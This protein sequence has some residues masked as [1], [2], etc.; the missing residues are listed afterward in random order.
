MATAVCGAAPDRREFEV[1][2]RQ[3]FEFAEKP[4]LARDGDRVTIRF[5]TRAF[6]DATVAIEKPRGRII[7]HLAC[8]VL[9][10]NAPE[11]FQKNSLEQTLVWDG[12]DDQ[13]KY[14]DEKD[15]V[16]VRVSLGLRARFERTLFWSPVKRWGRRNPLLA[17]APEGVYVF[18]PGGGVSTLQLFGHDGH[19]VRTVYPF[20]ADKV[21]TIEELKWY[22]FPQDGKRLPRK[23]GHRQCTLLSSGTHSKFYET[24]GGGLK[25]SMPDP[26]TGMAVHGKVIALAY[27]Y[28]NRF[29]T[30]GSS[31]GTSL[32]GARSG[33]R[34]VRGDRGWRG[35]GDEIDV[36]PA[37]LAFSPDA[38]WLYTAAYSWSEHYGT[39]GVH[40]GWLNGVGRVRFDGGGAVQPFAGNIEKESAGGTKP[41]EFRV[42]SGLACDGA[43]RVYVAD[44]L[45]DRVQVFSPAGKFL[46]QIDVPKPAEVA[47]DDKTGRIYVLSWLIAAKPVTFHRKRGLQEKWAVPPRLFVF[48]SFDDPKRVAAYDL[49]EGSGTPRHGFE[50][51]TW[52]DP[53]TVWMVAGRPARYRPWKRAGV[54]VI[55]LRDG[56]LQIT[57]DFG[58]AADRAIGRLEPPQYLRQRLY[59]NPTDDKVYLAEADAGVGKS[60]TDLLEIDPASGSIRRLS[61]PFDAED[62]AFDQQGRIYLRAL[63]DIARYDPKTWREIPFDYGEDRKGVGFAGS[64]GKRANVLSSLRIPCRRYNH[65]GGMMVNAR[66]DVVVG[67]HGGQETQRMR[68]AAKELFGD[69]GGYAFDLYP[70]RAT[71][72]LV[73]I[74]DR[75][76][77]AVHED[78]FPGIAF[79]HG[80]G[81][82]RDRSVYAMAMAHRVLG[83]KPYY[84]EATDTLVKV[85]PGRAKVYATHGKMVPVPL[86]K[87]LRPDRPHDIIG[88]GGARL[89]RAWV[90]RA[91]WFYGGVGYHGR[92]SKTDGFGCDCSNSRFDLD[93]FARSFAPEV[94]H[95]SVAVL[96]SAGNLILRVG[97]YGNVDD[98][99]PLVKAGGP[100]TPRSLGGDEVALF[101]APYVAIH[102]DRRLFIADPGN[103]RLLGVR[104]GY[105]ATET[106]A[107]R[108]V[109][110]RAVGRR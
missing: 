110:D 44:N 101:Y 98:G 69:K 65:H 81:I 104:L 67:I 70:G 88:R 60:T 59:A 2:R 63:R 54:Q 93:Y 80:V 102:T 16:T 51:D 18:D 33:V 35:G 40:E 4:T 78:A 79:M 49:P 25:H 82:D 23:R 73:L 34:I 52:T 12:K 39:G 100:P 85:R 83:G 8:G 45:N 19:Y 15:Q 77:K 10:P 106:V 97:T 47:V 87:E 62:I 53:P 32:R 30:D 55:T 6:C 20:P 109:A 38:K 95:C 103:H 42:P 13:G 94:E 96:D 89:G 27:V 107:L 99:M 1:K 105:A 76:G 37:T 5:K 58:R 31:G 68:E 29:G 28:L 75:R 48:G 14:V 108:D 90:E 22:A 64:K 61:L 72:G 84:N 43:G 7:R 71:A 56:T 66:G 41:G 91:E 3:P 46:K 9:G 74:F 26:A 50:I 92:H 11:P 17:A 24:M 57:K 36:G 21:K 86:T